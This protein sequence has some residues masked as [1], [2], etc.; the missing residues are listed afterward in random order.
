HD[1]RQVAS[2]ERAVDVS[3]EPLPTEIGQIAT[4]IDVR[5]TQHGPIDSAWIERKLAIAL[6]RLAA[7]ALEQAA[8]KQQLLPIDFQQIHRAGGRAGRSEKMD[9][10]GLREP[11]VR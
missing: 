4:V 8:L 3:L 7:T 10:H 1:A 9:E 2:S 5:V 11:L 6:H